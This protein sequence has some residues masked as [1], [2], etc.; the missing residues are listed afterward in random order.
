VRTWS[1]A[2][3]AR[4]YFADVVQPLLARR[5]PGLRYAAGRLG[6]GSDVLGLDDDRS[7]DHD[8]GLR[9][10]VL[11]DEA[12]RTALPAVTE[13]LE[14]EL[15]QDYRGLPV[16]F[17]TTWDPIVR[18]RAEVATVGDFATS[19]LG[20]N[21]LHPMS[22]IDWLILT[23]QSVLEVIAGPVFTDHTSELTAVRETLRWYPPDVDRYVLAAAWHRLSEQMPMVGRTAEVGD[24]VGSRLLCAGLA[25]DLIRLA[26]L[27]HRQWPPY[28]KWFGTLFARLPS[29]GELPD[30][31]RTA[32]G[33]QHWH[34]RESAIAG[35]AE[36]LL[37]LQRDRGL[38]TPAHGVIPFWDRPYRTISSDV[39]AALLAG[40]TDPDL[41]ALPPGIGSIEQWCDNADVLAKP[42][43]RP[44]IA[45]TYRAW[46]RR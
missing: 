17:A 46:I 1:G 24:E 10:T 20:A 14:Q 35:S 12:D 21:P 43:R 13:L 18:P 38:P 27:L 30:L 34:E 45:A 16:R 40:I 25:A 39:P 5:L 37:R 7:R 36:A 6:S 15:P 41:A 42:E 11:V 28:R 9:L 29:A 4:A 26:F 33:G 22:A 32:A 23:G 3:V 44:A 19:R 2:A 8:W 31:L